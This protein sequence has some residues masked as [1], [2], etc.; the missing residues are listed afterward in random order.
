MALNIGNLINEEAQLSL[1]QN[2]LNGSFAVEQLTLALCQKS[3]QFLCD[4]D[5]NQQESIAKL[6]NQI[7]ETRKI[8]KERFHS[9]KDML[10]GINAH[11]NPFDQPSSEWAPL[12]EALGFPFL[13]F[14]KLAN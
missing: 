12:P 4:L 2:P 10:I 7:D 1:I 8:R 14:E 6:R 3:W 11:E 5:A 9:G 13:I